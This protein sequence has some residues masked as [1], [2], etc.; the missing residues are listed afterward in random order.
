MYKLAYTFIFSLFL[1]I[2][3]GPKHFA[4]VQLSTYNYGIDAKRHGEQKEIA[5]FLK[6]YADSV[7]SSM[8]EVIGMLQVQLTKS[9]PDCSLG[10]LMTDAYK[11]MASVKFNRKIDVA[12]M[13]YGGIRLNSLEQGGITTRKVFE[14]MPFDNM[15]VLLEVTG[16]QLQACMDNIAA[17]GG[18]PISGGT[19]EIKNKKAFNLTVG[20]EPVVANKNYMLCVSDY[21]ADGGDDS[22][23]LKGIKQLNI[24]YLQRDAILEYVKKYYTI[25]K[26]AGTRVIKE[27][28]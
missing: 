4:P 19:Y 5:G 14:L 11:E 23:V 17:R 21:V 9:W 28:N 6:P 18:W 27:E 7:N 25:G 3:C 26:P 15:T 10:H 20:G 8:D 12:L 16:E 24:G 1:L 22:N 13:N 2:A